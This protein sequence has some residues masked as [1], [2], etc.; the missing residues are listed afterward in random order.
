MKRGLSEWS[1]IK[2]IEAERVNV[3]DT[4]V[5]SMYCR[6]LSSKSVREIEGEYGAQKTSFEPIFP[7]SRGVGVQVQL[8]VFFI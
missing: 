5:S 8:W 6:I 1:A 4:T 3:V 7:Q 2:H